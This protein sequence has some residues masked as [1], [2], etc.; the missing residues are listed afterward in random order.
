M[1]S[2][3]TGES[4][5][6]HCPTCESVARVVCAASLAG[7]T[8]Q[9]SGVHFLDIR[10]PRRVNWSGLWLCAVGCLVLGL[11]ALLLAPSTGWYQA[12]EVF[13]VFAVTFAGLGLWQTRLNRSRMHSAEALV[14]KTHARALYCS[15]CEC[16]YFDGRKLPAGIPIGKAMSAA[17][18]RRRLWYACGFTKP[19]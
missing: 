18:Y 1:E 3:D 5:P 13:A 11:A 12:A 2:P 6:A 15:G 4:T 10:L 19:I 7:N 16:V 17:E 9:P 8:A 14:Y